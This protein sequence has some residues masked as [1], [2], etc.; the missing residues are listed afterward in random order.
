MNAKRFGLAL[1]AA[2][3]SLSIA[4]QAF[5][6][7]AAHMGRWTTRD[8]NGEIG[9]FGME[10]PPDGGMA[11]GFVDRDRHDVMAQYNDGM[12]LYEYV[13]SSPTLLTDPS[14]LLVGEEV[15]VFEEVVVA[16]S[17]PPGAVIV[18]GTVAA[19]VTYKVSECTVAPLTG[20]IVDWWTYPEESEEVECRLIGSAPRKRQ[21]EVRCTYDCGPGRQKEIFIPWPHGTP[22][23]SCDLKKNF[24]F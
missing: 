8:P 4:E 19:C 7:Y 9:R 6:Y 16:C 2:C 23:P 17:T 3:L 18:G 13:Q 1:V 21:Q 22:E 20:W 5:A 14:G 11:V 15:I 24:W 10:T 12:N